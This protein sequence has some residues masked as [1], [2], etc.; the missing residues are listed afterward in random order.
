[1]LKTLIIGYGNPDRED[2][3]VAWHVLEKLAHRFNSP[4]AT[5]D[6]LAL[7]AHLTHSGGE[8][9]TDGGSGSLLA[10]AQR[11]VHLA[12][13]LQLTPEMAETLA[14]YQRVCFIDAHTG[15]YSEEIRVAPVEPGYQ[16]S[17]FTHHLTPESC[18]TLAETLSGHVP[19]GL[20][21]SI[22]GYRFGYGIEL[23]DQTAAL[24][25]KALVQILRWINQRA[26]Q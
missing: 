5:V 25:D 15:A 20:M 16:A 21:V 24:V 23:S 17:P 11:P 12:F 4:I 13:A 2:D 26:V 10:L 3:G 18:L 7:I 22:R 14:Q 9:E 1:M 6:E 19:A 8:T